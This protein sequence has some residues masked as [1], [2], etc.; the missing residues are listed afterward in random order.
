MFK[1]LSASPKSYLAFA[2][3]LTAMAFQA[4]DESPK[5]KSQS[6][7]SSAN[8]ETITPSKESVLGN[9][10]NLEYL[11][12]LQQTSS[13]RAAQGKAIL[14]RLSEE[15]PTVIEGFH[16]GNSTS[17]E[18]EGSQLGLRDVGFAALTL[19]G[20]R[21]SLNGREYQKA[22]MDGDTPLIVEEF[23]LAGFYQFNGQEVELS[24]KGEVKGLVGI[25][26]YQVVYDYYDPGRDFDLLQ[27]GADAENLRQLIF[28]LEDGH[29]RIYEIECVT[30][31]DGFCMEIQPGE[32]LFDLHADEISMG[33]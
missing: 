9:W 1:S 8:T 13:P 33:E 5:N 25:H 14:L 29:L 15:K 7:D 22:P 27:M 4:C 10:I 24:A 31:D 17:W 12:Q 21:L 18:T 26:Q 30:E 2:F 20:D 16:E 6:T 11:E 3:A 19:V 32:L 28:R 23:L